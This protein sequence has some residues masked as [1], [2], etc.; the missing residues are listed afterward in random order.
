MANRPS[1]LT[2][3]YTQFQS[4]A[5]PER[6]PLV[7]DQETR[8]AEALELNKDARLINCFAE[9]NPKTQEWE[10]EKRPAYYQGSLLPGG[11]NGLGMYS[12]NNALYS[13]SGSLLFKDFTPFVNVL[14]N[15]S[16]YQFQQVLGT[17]RLVLKNRSQ[18]WYTDGTTLTQI[19]DPDYPATTVPGMAYLDGTLYVMTPNAAIQ[20]SAIDDPTSWDP[21]NTIIARNEPDLGIGLIKHQ[22]YVVAL[23]QW[24]TQAFENVGN[25]TG[26]PLA[27]VDGAMYYYGCQNGNSITEIDGEHFW[28]SRNKSAGAQAV[29][30]SQLQ[31][32]VISTPVI[33]RIL[34]RFSNGAFGY[35]VKICGHKFWILTIGSTFSLVYDVDQKLWYR[36]TDYTGNAPFPM[37]ASSYDS[38]GVTYVLGQSDSRF[39]KL[40]DS[41]TQT[42]DNGLIYPVDIYTGNF[43][44]GVDRRKHLNVK[45]FD[46][47]VV[48]GSELLVRC[49]DN[50][51]KD[52]TNFRKVD[53]SQNRPQLVNC[54]SFYKRSY[55]YRHQKATPF[56]ISSVGLQIDIGTL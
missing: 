54:G 11:G 22:N 55:H 15:G 37:S 20:G 21:V 27:R 30:L 26:S 23:K 1:K 43:D 18:G 14:D 10:V 35:S 34:T 13:V 19:T 7:T 9:Y 12:W 47:D 42:T 52:Y 6:W 3:G 46:T 40:E 48:P 5:L 41:F 29:K 38:V 28:I 16:F 2:R 4:V 53:L 17:P 44:F 31:L 49:S 45:T 32:T 51:Y 24:S 25:P 56:R 39:Y 36:W 8:S 33:D 50:D